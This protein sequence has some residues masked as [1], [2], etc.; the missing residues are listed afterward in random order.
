MILEGKLQYKEEGNYTPKTQE[1]YNSTPAKPKEKK[2]LHTN[3]HTH[4]QR[5]RERERERERGKHNV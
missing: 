5:E 4:I 2:N 3:T 1:I